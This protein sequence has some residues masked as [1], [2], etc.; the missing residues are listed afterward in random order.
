MKLLRVINA[1][2]LFDILSTRWQQCAVEGETKQATM[3][4]SFG[5]SCDLRQNNQSSRFTLT[6]NMCA[7]CDDTAKNPASSML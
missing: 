4:L 5:L 1:G 6:G 7:V 2:N 3:T